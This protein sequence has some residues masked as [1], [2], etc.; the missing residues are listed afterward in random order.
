MNYWLVKS[1]PFKYSWDDFVKEG[2]SVWD[3]VRNYQ[4][5]NNMKEMKKGD[6]VFFYHSNVGME[7]IGLAEVKKEFFQDPT[8]EDPRWV[9]VEIIPIKKFNKTVTLK[10]MKSDDRLS[11]LALIKQS[12]LSVT[13]VG[14]Q[15]FDIILSL[16]E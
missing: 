1:E 3:G 2:K 13:P 6:W 10:M 15:E 8:T 11:N 5:R 14:K 16:A 7:V 12:R 9:V 4:A